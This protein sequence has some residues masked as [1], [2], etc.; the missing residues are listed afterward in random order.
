MGKMKY[1]HQKHTLRMDLVASYVDFRDS[2]DY[3]L[4][5]GGVNRKY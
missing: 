1:H 5:V 3:H 4:I 2:N